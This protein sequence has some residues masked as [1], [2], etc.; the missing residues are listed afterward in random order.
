[1]AIQFDMLPG[2]L[3]RPTET[4]KKLHKSVNMEDGLKLWLIVTL[5]S[6]VFA[7]VTQKVTMGKT[8]GMY[9]SGDPTYAAAYSD[10]ALLITLISW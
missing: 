8:M 9:P 10:G 5:I 1:M 7:F 2:V 4:F 6:S 3:F